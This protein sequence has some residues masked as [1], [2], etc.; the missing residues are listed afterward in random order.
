[1]ELPS[2]VEAAG[3]SHAGERDPEGPDRVE[4]PDEVDARLVGEGG[5]EEGRPGAARMVELAVPAVEPVGVGQPVEVVPTQDAAVA[6]QPRRAARG[7]GPSAEA[8]EEELV[9]GLV[10]LDQE[11]VALENVPREPGPEHPSAD[12]L[13]A[14]RSD[15]Q[16]VE[17]ALL[18]V[19]RIPRGDREGQ[20]DHVGR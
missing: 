18:D 7:E 14:R 19:P 8:E 13:T 15:T 17:D 2:P 9:P 20:L 12:A 10:V 6:H 5:P 1:V 4:D 3:E 11:P 16:V